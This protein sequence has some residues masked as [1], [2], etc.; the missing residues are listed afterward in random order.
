MAKSFP[1]TGA[2]VG[3]AAD[4]SALTSPFAG[5]QFFETDNKLLYIY[6]GS[7]W[8]LTVTGT[9]I[10]FCANG[11]TSYTPIN[12]AEFKF[13]NIVTNSGSGYSA[14][15]GRFTAPITG[16]Y[17]FHYSFLSESSANQVDTRLKINQ[18]T[19]LA[20]AYSG[21][22]TGYKPGGASAGTSL[23]A[24]QYVSVV[25]FGASYAHP[26]PEHQVFS[27]YLVK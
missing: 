16:Y 12:N 25:S 18:S 21:T 10:I 26:D 23:T 15:T 24:G 19:I 7:T 9:P 8:I 5:M 27:G 3:L 20:S 6:D 22:G 4:R 14:S 1:N 17:M 13:N 2:T 11:L